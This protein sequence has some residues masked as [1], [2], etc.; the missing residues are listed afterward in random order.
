MGE[1]QVQ[2]QNKISKQ[3]KQRLKIRERV[4]FLKFFTKL[5]RIGHFDHATRIILPSTASF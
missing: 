1:Y 3:G 4:Q 5:S 2:F